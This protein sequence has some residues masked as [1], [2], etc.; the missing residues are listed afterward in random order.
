MLNA[1]SVLSMSLPAQK[2]LE[3]LST[4][5]HVYDISLYTCYGYGWIVF[6]LPRIK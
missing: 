1:I 3:P 6:L 5:W 4:V 2:T